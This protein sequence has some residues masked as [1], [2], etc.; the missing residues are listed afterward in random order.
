MAQELAQ[1]ASDGAT[2]REL[3]LQGQVQGLQD[4]L[5][6]QKD[7]FTEV[8]AKTKTQMQ[9]AVLRNDGAVAE[10]QAQSLA[11]RSERDT[12]SV[13]LQAVRETLEAVQ[14]QV[15]K[16]REEVKR[17]D[18]QK[19]Q[20][21][22][23]VAQLQD[24]MRSLA[25]EAVEQQL[26]QLRAQVTEAEEAVTAARD[27]AGEQMQRERV[28]AGKER[29]KLAADAKAQLRIAQAAT[30]ARDAAVKEK[31]DLARELECARRE[32]KQALDRRGD[33]EAGRVR[34][35]TDDVARLKGEKLALEEKLK[36]GSETER[37]DKEAI[38]K[39][40]ARCDALASAQAL[41]AN[42]AEASVGGSSSSAPN[43]PGLSSSFGFKKGKGATASGWGAGGEAEI[44]RLKAQMMERDKEIER[45]KGLQTARERGGLE[46]EG[47]P[48]R[49][50]DG[51]GLY[52]RARE[53]E[54]KQRVEKLEEQLNA[55]VGFAYHPPTNQ[56]M[57]LCVSCLCVCVCVCV[58]I[59]IL[60][61]S[62]VS[63]RLFF[64]LIICL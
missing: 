16:S 42:N 5:R 2:E 63:T 14:E 10:A 64:C 23:Q 27:A 49:L 8:M 40:R 46:S 57:Y 45:L 21:L 12:L 56:S 58:C 43:T 11:L 1:R 20:A 29:E 6:A 62:A 47:S 60:H 54:L 4:M 35:L 37:K 61:R 28:K 36:A 33:K 7:K 9:D 39:L 24:G 59:F 38:A 22:R 44:K 50:G 19:A 48:S 17:S 26:A 32:A 25:P 55:A 53:K 13:E 3:Q 52:Y 15:A 34:S 30:S 41:P 18:E 31:D 51:S